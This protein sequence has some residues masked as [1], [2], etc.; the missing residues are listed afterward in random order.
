MCMLFP[1]NLQQYDD[2]TFGYLYL[3]GN[4]TESFAGPKVKCFQQE[5]ESREDFISKNN[6]TFQPKQYGSNLTNDTIIN[7]YEKANELIDV[8]KSG[9]AVD[10]FTT[11]RMTNDERFYFYVARYLPED[12]IPSEWLDPSYS[13]EQE[14]EIKTGLICRGLSNKK[15]TDPSQPVKVRREL[16][17]LGL[18]LDILSKDPSKEIR[19]IVKKKSDNSLTIES[20]KSSN[21]AKKINYIK[22]TLPSL[23]EDQQKLFIDALVKDES[24]DVREALA[25]NGY[26]IDILKHDPNW[27][28]QRGVIASNKLKREDIEKIAQNDKLHLLVQLAIAKYNNH[29]GLEILTPYIKNLGTPAKIEFVK[30]GKCLSEIVNSLVSNANKDLIEALGTYLNANKDSDE[31]IN[32]IISCVTNRNLYEKFIKD[33]P[34]HVVQENEEYSTSSIGKIIYKLYYTGCGDKKY[35]RCFSSYRL[36][37]E[38]HTR[39]LNTM[40]GN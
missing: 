16:A 36:Y 6:I 33:K 27:K 17:N 23:P 25:E 4:E 15:Y 11:F 26:A 7:N 14:I 3:D 9:Y 37:K 8:I 40:N 18:F 13:G 22:N 38:F 5:G 12:D 39:L 35:S 32:L 20:L 21:N 28:V 30:Y 31:V 19:D 2:G 24:E 1:M 29:E 10:Y 34:E